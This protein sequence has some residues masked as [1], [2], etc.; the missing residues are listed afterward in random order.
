MIELWPQP[1]WTWN[2][3]TAGTWDHLYRAF[4]LLEAAAWFAFAALVLWRW[5]RFRHSPLE[6]LYAA[7]F[8]AFGVTDLLEAS[9]QSA[10]LVLV[11]GG[12]LVALLLLRQVVRKRWYPANS[13]Y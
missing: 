4:N 9:R 3:E 1:W 5:T 7:T 10:P 8:A 12:I 11:K 13:L 2:P 6:M